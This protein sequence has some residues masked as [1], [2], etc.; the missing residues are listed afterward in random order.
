M[1]HFSSENREQYDIVRLAISSELVK[2]GTNP[3]PKCHFKKR[4]THILNVYEA[5]MLP[6]ANVSSSDAESY[7]TDHSLNTDEYKHVNSKKKVC[8]VNQIHMKLKDL[9]QDSTTVMVRLV[10]WESMVQYYMLT[11]KSLNRQ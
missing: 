4:R 7:V 9:Q 10:L 3:E 1:K 8:H 2:T 11:M 5:N 6:A